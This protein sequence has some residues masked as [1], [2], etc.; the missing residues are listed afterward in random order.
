[1]CNGIGKKNN[2]V[3]YK[4]DKYIHHTRHVKPKVAYLS[5]DFHD[6]ATMHLMAG[7]F[8]NQNHNK[9]DYY[10][11]S[12]SDKVGAGSEVYERVRKSFKNFLWLM[13]KVIKKFVNY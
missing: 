3:E 6:H 9:F 1:M 13:K 5:Y 8:E 2:L 7:V 4:K 12:Y 11:F 10:A